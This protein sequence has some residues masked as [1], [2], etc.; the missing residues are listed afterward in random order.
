MSGVPRIRASLAMPVAALALMLAPAQALGGPGY[1][2]ISNGPNELELR[3]HGLPMRSVHA[4]DNQN[5][6]GIDFL[7]PVDG[8]LFDR[9]A[10]ELPQWISMSYANFDNGMIRSPRPVTFLAHSESDGFTLRIIARGPAPDTTAQIRGSY[11]EHTP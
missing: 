3:F 1:E 5:A 7:E 11:G 4:D 9:L 8:A 10:G 2:V 6:L